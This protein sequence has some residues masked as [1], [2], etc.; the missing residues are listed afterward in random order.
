MQ[1]RAAIDEDGPPLVEQHINAHRFM[2]VPAVD[3]FSYLIDIVADVAQ[4]KPNPVW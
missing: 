3:A 4:H 2:P 1:M